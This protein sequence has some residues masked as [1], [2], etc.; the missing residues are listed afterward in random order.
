[1]PKRSIG[2]IVLLVAL[3]SLAFAG[4]SVAQTPIP[5][6]VQAA[7]AQFE[8]NPR[9]TH[10]TW[11]VHV[12][13]RDTGEVLIDRL[14]E[15]LF[16]PGSIQKT[17]TTS[18]ALAEYG[19]DHRF[20]TPVHRTGRVRGG[21][22][23]GDLVLVASGDYSFGLREQEDGTLGFNST[24]QIDHNYGDTGLPGPTLVPDS[25]PLAGVD[26]LAE[27][28]RQSGIR[29]VNGDVLIDD[30]L[31]EEFTLFPDGTISPIW[32]N[33]NVIDMVTKPTDVGERTNL[34]WRPKTPAIRVVNKAKTGPPGSQNTLAVSGPANGKVTLRGRIP[35]DSDPVLNI[36]QIPDAT[37]FAR[38][39]FIA[40]L[41]DEGVEVSAPTK[42]PNPA[43]ELP[44]QS[45]LKQDNQVAERVSY[46]FSEYVKVILKVSYNRGADLM[47]CLLAVKRGS[48]DC[49]EGLQS[50]VEN[51]AALGVPPQTTF[52]FDGAGSDDRDR[53]SP[54]AATNFLRNAY[55]QSYGQEFYDGLPIFGVDGTLAET[56]EGSPAAGKIRAK[57]GN[58]VAFLETGGGIA[59]AQTRIGYIEAASGRQLV[60]ADLIRDIPL[61]EPTD[62]FDIDKDM[63]AVET[64][65]QQGY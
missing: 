38:T 30:R 20:R 61:A 57:T 58:R 24:P 62:I 33:E 53:T 10:S 31:F 59:G 19:P 56:G 2:A 12:V 15:K 50:I 40:A 5:P 16:V 54:I 23:D 21:R 45:A 51:N 41:R 26:D 29:Q 6:S 43:E 37:A 1:M 65:I 22:L 42:G 28:V 34:R 48:T 27:Q 17:F 9:Y 49:E 14:G 60:Y 7:M 13:D 18:A 25:H 46:P 36:A 44:R 4:S 35:A 39:A 8:S 3:V 64:A 63:T 52:A 32:V 47:V 55:T 11:G